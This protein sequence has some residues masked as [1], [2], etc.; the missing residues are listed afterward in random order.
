M[1]K[2]TYAYTSPYSQPYLSIEL[3]IFNKDRAIIIDQIIKNF[4]KYKIIFSFKNYKN[5]SEYTYLHPLENHQL[6]KCIFCD[7]T[8]N[9]V[10]FKKRPHVIPY[11]LGNHFLLHYEECDECNEHFGKTLEDALDKYLKPHRTLNQ[12]KN[13]QGD[14]IK[15]VLGRNKEFKYDHENN[16]YLIKLDEKNV[17]YEA[18]SK[19]ITF[20]FNQ[21][22]YCPLLVYKAFMKILFGLLPRDQ[23]YK[24]ESLRNW[25]IN[26]DQN[27]KF[28]SPLH[29]LKTGLDGLAETPLD[30]V[31]CHQE[32]STLEN[33]KI[34]MPAQEHFEY[35]AMIR[36]GNKFF[37]LPIFTD[38]NLLKKDYMKSINKP[39]SFTLTH[40]PKHNHPNY[41]VIDFSESSKIKTKELFNFKITKGEF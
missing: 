29:V 10:S 30:I 32:V 37:E 25:I 8:S 35:I 9:E 2:Y 1:S 4:N 6:K 41:E 14:F 27:F 23:L 28:I 13:R 26:P 17:T 18:D 39:F 22:P 21:E 12:Q 11:L 34:S 5:L 36:F 24:F 19:T 15:T 33:F 20:T 7:R 3:E 16:K 40:F 38:L 31:I